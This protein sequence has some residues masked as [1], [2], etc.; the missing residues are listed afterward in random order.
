[1]SGETGLR[2]GLLGRRRVPVLLQDAP[3]QCGPACLR[4]IAAYHGRHLDQHFPHN[5]CKGPV[6]GYTLRGLIRLANSIGL[7]RNLFQTFSTASTI[8]L[9]AATGRTRKMVSIERSQ[10]CS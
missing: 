10:A 1:M 2:P 8:P 5:H 4:A 3:A 6:R 9:D 7:S